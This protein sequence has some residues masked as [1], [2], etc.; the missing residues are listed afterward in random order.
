[1]DI[2]RIKTVIEE[3]P[4]MATTLGMEFLSTPDDDTVMARMRVN[5][6]NCQPFGML[7]GGASLAL[8]ETLAGVGSQSICPGQVCVGINVSGNH[9]K[10]A[11][12][13]EVVT[14]LARIVHRGNTL[15]VW[16]IDITDPSGEVVSTARVTNYVVNQNKRKSK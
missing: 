11:P 12:V 4:N 13:G 15:H 1:M 9:V 16:N 10:A 6:T 7:S 5:W 8:A 14:A 2:D 3:N